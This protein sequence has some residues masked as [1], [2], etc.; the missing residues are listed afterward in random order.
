MR[1][2]AP[3]GRDVHVRMKRI[4]QRDTE[5][6]LLLRKHLTAWGVRYRICPQS[7]PGRPDVANSARR[8]AVF[9][10]GCFWH[11]HRGC[12]LAT[13][14]KTNTEF[15]RAKLSANRTRDR[16]KRLALEAMGFYVVEVWQCQLRDLRVLRRIRDRLG[17]R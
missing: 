12:G 14:P 5:P 11:G 3:S 6:E 17:R 8:W 9:V 1:A 2:R 4:R 13:L 16:R 10:H 15:W 7:L